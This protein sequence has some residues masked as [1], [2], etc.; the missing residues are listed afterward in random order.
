MIKVTETTTKIPASIKR[1]LTKY[2]SNQFSIFK[3]SVFQIYP[4]RFTM[5]NIHMENG[6]IRVVFK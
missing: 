1:L 6:K 4:F 2:K 5:G 3:K